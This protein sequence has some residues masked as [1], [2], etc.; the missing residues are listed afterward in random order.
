MKPRS[1]PA[2]PKNY[3]SPRNRRVQKKKT[4]PK[5][6]EEFYPIRQIIDE[7]SKEGVIEYLVDWEPKDGKTFDPEWKIAK[8]VTEAAIDEWKEQKAQEAKASKGIT[9]APQNGTI[10]SSSQVNPQE[11]ESTQDSTQGSEQVQE[12]R[13]NT[14]NNQ[15]AAATVVGAVEL[16]SEGGADSSQDTSVHQGPAV[17]RGVP[18]VVVLPVPAIGFEP[19]AFQV[20][21]PTQQSTIADSQEVS[22]TSA[23]EAPN[24]CQGTAI[25]SQDS[26]AYSIPS[27]QASTSQPLAA[28][29]HQNESSSSVPRIGSQPVFQTQP[30]FDWEIE[31]ATP[32]IAPP[33]SSVV[34]ASASQDTSS[35]HSHHTNNSQAAQ[36]VPPALGDLGSQSRSDFSVFDEDRDV[37]ASQSHAHI[38]SQ[39]SSSSQALSELNVNTRIPAS[40]DQANRRALPRIEIPPLAQNIR[41]SSFTS[42]SGA[43]STPASKM[44]SATT[45]TPLSARERLRQLRDK[46]FGGSPSPVDSTTEQFPTRQSANTPSEPVHGDVPAPLISPIT[47]APPTVGI[48][49]L[50][51]A[52]FHPSVTHTL[53]SN[54]TDAVPNPVIDATAATDAVTAPLQINDSQMSLDQSSAIDANPM[55]ANDV[56]SIE[57]SIFQA[58]AQQGYEQAPTLNPSALTLS[59]ERDMEA[60]PSIPTD[61]GLATSLPI[62]TNDEAFATNL[63][64]PVSANSDD[65]SPDDYPPSL[66]PE[67]PTGPN[68]Y[69]VTL[70]LYSPTRPQYNNIIRDN[71]NL[72]HD[73]ASFFFE[74]PH[75][76]P[77]PATIEKLDTMFTRLFDI[78]DLPPFLETLPSMSPDQIT[79][80]T[81]G[82]NAK[83]AFVAELLDDL[84]L[85]GSDKRIL[86]L[87][88][89]G[90]PHD[91]L[92]NLIKTR[93]FRLM[94]IDGQLTNPEG[95]KQTLTVT[96]VSTYDDP[97]SIPKDADVIIAF[98]H[99]FRHNLIAMNHS[100][101]PLVLLLVNSASIQHLN[102]RIM[103][104]L[105]PLERKNALMLAL[106]K[107]MR[108]V[109]EPDP[110]EPLVSTVEKF[111]KRIHLP[112]DD[113]FYWEPYHL[114]SE[115]FEDLYQASSQMDLTQ[116]S[117]GE[118]G[119]SRKRSYMDGEG[120]DAMA[121]RLKI[122]QPEVVQQ[123]AIRLPGKVRRLLGPDYTPDSEV[124][125]K[126]TIPVSLDRLYMIAKMIS[127]LK[128]EAG[129]SK[130]DVAKYR[131]LCNRT[132]EEVRCH[133]RMEN[134]IQQRYMEALEDRGNFEHDCKNAQE[135]ARILQKNLETCQSENY[136]LKTSRTE[137][138]KKLAEKI[139][140]MLNSGNPDLVKM[141]EIDKDLAAAKMQ[142]QQLEKRL[143]VAQSDLDYQRNNYQQASQRAA[144]LSAE[145]RTY[146]RQIEDLARK[147]NDN[148][149]EVHKVQA[150]NETR[151][152][153]R[154]YHEEK[155]IRLDRET[156]L[157]RL[158]DELKAIKNGRRD[159]RGTSVPRS[160]R[161]SAL[162]SP[163]NGGRGPS[164]MGGASSSRGTSPAPPQEGGFPIPFG[165]P[166]R[167]PHLRDGRF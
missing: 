1:T 89:P 48:D 124:Q 87:A 25:D 21:Q 26:A 38:D 115:I 136:A 129:A 140:E 65:E 130:R 60:S 154:M 86:L 159:T 42:E 2:T 110:S 153:N 82:T 77:D 11:D 157:A 84:A 69:V 162:S 72:M 92:T 123:R 32:H 112:E 71:E 151:E 97:S 121:K 85:L 132:A 161:L 47:L 120:D 93:G 45:P 80:H 164:A 90:Q 18:I 94:G 135:Q 9:H 106:V 73:Y 99:T 29:S 79:K 74:F 100:P 34:P 111:V 139:T 63:A 33:E 14:G 117:A 27:H 24:S 59:I 160:P 58:A 51:E 66:L 10:V 46:N 167:L 50:S 102:M 83:F 128:Q 95:A 125:G 57:P 6:I 163:R 70:P 131:D 155:A 91:L 75:K 137:L 76:T 35:Q 156:E 44:N 88:R 118:I 122:S 78:C 37:L 105:Q 114:P 116:L 81:I 104:N 107:A 166:N 158:R 8:D 147:A 39:P 146:E 144:E 7:R 103:E 13:G 31:S 68:E 98:D 30:P 145:N 62:P 134:K 150:R 4:K 64:D 3:Q 22:A 19:S 149:I 40:Q 17:N 23:S 127:G 108:F 119:G 53:M 126:T 113:D 101:H 43:P 143:I 5:E 15:P 16:G 165:G 28:P 133:Q 152:L 36:I 55:L 67:V 142:V 61:D 56:S 54:A 138:E 12:Q 20:I 52:P 109:E 41:H 141:T 96:V 49:T 148:I